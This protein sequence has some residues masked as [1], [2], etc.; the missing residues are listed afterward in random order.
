MGRATLNLLF[1]GVNTMKLT[2]E[3]QQEFYNKFCRM[4]TSK[5]GS[6]VDWDIDNPARI[7]HWI[8]SLLDKKLIGEEKLKQGANNLKTQLEKELDN[9][10]KLSLE[11]ARLDK[12]LKEQKKKFVKD[13]ENL[14]HCNPY[15]VKDPLEDCLIFSKQIGELKSKYKA[16]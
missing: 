10:H 4:L 2:E 16:K 9:N 11:I 15:E 7:I 1:K 8:G 6:Q 3:D 14:Y 5:Q 13:V 12:K